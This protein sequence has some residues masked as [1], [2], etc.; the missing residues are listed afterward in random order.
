MD[1]SKLSSTDK[2]GVYGS[3]ALIIG[4]IIGGTVSA[5][6]WLG[7]LAAI[8]MLAVIFLPQMSATTTLPGS[9]GSLM[10]LTGGIA[11]VV[12]I[13]GLLS[14]IGWLGLYFSILPLQAIFFLIAVAGGLVMGWA[15]WQAF[16]AEGGKFQIGSGPSAGGPPPSSPPPSSNPPPSS[17]PPPSSGPP[18]A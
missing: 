16:Q 1:F 10:V 11:A 8:A 9:H 13:L 18:S 3:V 2:L 5:V 12:M 15:G 6:G 14:G 4:A 17:S 7:V